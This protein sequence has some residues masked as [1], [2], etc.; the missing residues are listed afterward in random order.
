MAGVDRVQAAADGFSYRSHC[1]GT[2]CSAL[3][4]ILS[5]TEQ[6]DQTGARREQ[7]SFATRTTRCTIMPVLP[8][9]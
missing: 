3:C 2:K 6:N 9:L 5:K 4:R 7:V 1:Y 8:V